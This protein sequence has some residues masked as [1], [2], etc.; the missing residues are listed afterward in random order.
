MGNFSTGQR[1]SL[2][3]SGLTTS[4]EDITL[5]PPKTQFA[6]SRTVSRLADFAD[7]PATPPTEA[8][9]EERD[10]KNGGR[11]FGDKSNRK[12]L[13][14]TETDG[15]HNRESWTSVRDRRALGGDEEKAE[16]DERK[17]GRRD[18]ATDGERRNG[19]S[20]RPDSR[21]HRDE[22][23]TTAERQGGWREREKERRDRDFDNGHNDKE[24]EWMDDPAPK[25]QEDDFGELTSMP[26]NQED[27]EKWKKAQHARYRKSTDEPE[28]VPAEPP[29]GAS[30]SEVPSAKSIASLK[31]EGI[32]DKPFGNWNEGKS[33][34]GAAESAGVQ[35]SAA[36]AKGNAKSKTSRFMPMFKKDELKDELLAIASSSPEPATTAVN[37]S[38]EDKAGFENILR[39][40]GNTGVGQEATP[41][42]PASPPPRQVSNGTKPKSRFTGF[43][44]QTKSPDRMQPPT[45]GKQAPSKPV[46]S[47]MLQTGRGFM[48]EPNNIFG[49]TLGEEISRD[50]R[51]T[52]QAVSTAMSPDSILQTN[53]PKDPRSQTGRMNDIFLDPTHRGAS[54]P[55]TNIEDLLAS[56]RNQQRQQGVD[57]KNSEFLL[58]LLQNK[59][60]SRPPSQQ[61][62]QAPPDFQ[63][64]REQPPIIP[65]THA[66][67]PRAPPPPGLF[68]DQLLRNHPQEP[69]RQEQPSMANNDM[70]QRRTSQRAPPGFF[71]EPGLFQQQQQQHQQQQHHHHQRN[72]TESARQFGQPAASRRMSNQI[73]IPPMQ[74][75]PHAQPPS[76]PFPG[77]FMQSPNSAVPPPGFHPHM[78]RHPPGIHNI[79]NIFSAPQPP[80]QQPQREPM[81][82]NGLGAVGGTGMLPRTTSPPNAP[83][84]FF[85]GPQGLPQGF[86]PMRSPQEGMPVGA[87]GGGRGFD[88]FRG[89]GQGR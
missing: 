22:R 71:D 69:P 14:A 45:T 25:V 78:P 56:Q 5:G 50:Q 20:E 28:A 68:E 58:G 23:R 77:D 85:A 63:L 74:I 53:V 82:F 1:P 17:F 39:M 6:S 3:R 18:H 36:S 27:F 49:G 35:T 76:A 86:M 66:P 8:A 51:P 31:L 2:L 62:R 9:L 40:L 67:K 89:L 81:G 29:P 79:P 55:D 33:T 42:E 80:K 47:E 30:A 32:V 83:P 16:G 84:G 65:E 13:G 11:T 12:S 41:N 59:G 64:W 73:N 24:P 26:K 60:A 21:W 15:R 70:V 75:L 52:A 57:N 7:K 37:G 10:G 61:L 46:E 44:D 19:Y 87:S 54:T 34:D 72:F 43:F 4:R 48:E 88:A 38:A